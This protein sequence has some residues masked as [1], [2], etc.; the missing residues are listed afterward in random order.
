MANQNF[1]RIEI[2]TRSNGSLSKPDATLTQTNLV[3]GQN[4]HV[5][6]DQKS[7][8]SINLRKKMSVVCDAKFYSSNL[9][10]STINKTIDDIKLRNDSQN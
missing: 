1:K 8:I 4:L 6:L 3:P 10:F 9:Q 2:K 5:L 7:L